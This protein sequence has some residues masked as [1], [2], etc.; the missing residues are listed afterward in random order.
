M[1]VKVKIPLTLAIIPALLVTCSG[2]R[3]AI[4]QVSL[5][6][7]SPAFWGILV[8]LPVGKLIGM[9]GE[10][11]VAWARRRFG[12]PTDDL[13]GTARPTQPGWEHRVAEFLTPQSPRT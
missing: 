10:R 5:A 12:I 2:D 8:A 7:L 1:E 11:A 6:E 13:G 4:P 3:Y 9:A